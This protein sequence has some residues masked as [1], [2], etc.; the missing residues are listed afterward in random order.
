MSRQSG[1]FLLQ[2]LLALSLVFAFVPFV[3]SRLAARDTDAQMYSTTR[4]VETASI[5][6]R[7]FIRENANYLPYD[8]TVI[9]GDAFADTL[10][11]YGL[12]LGF[13]PHTALGQDIALVIEKSPYEVTAR[14][15]LTDGG[16]SWLRRAEL[17]RRI[18]FYAG[19]TDGMIVVG[20]PL[21]EAFT[22][23]VRRDG[24]T[25]TGFLTDLDMGANT[26]DNAGTVFAYRGMFNALESRG[27]TV[28]G[29][30]NGRKVRSQI[31]TMTASRAV[32]QSTSGESALSLTR[33]ELS[34]GSINART[35]ARFGD[36]GSFT[37]NAAGVYDFSMTA[38]RTG[39]TG[40][41]EW[42][43]RGSVVA[44]RINFNVERL[45]ISASI[46]AT[47]GQDVFVMPDELEYSSKSG[48]EADILAASNITLRDQTSDALVDGQ[49]G[50]VV[51]DIRPAGVS[52]LPD[53]LVDG[54]DNGAF[55]ILKSAADASSD[56]VD[57]KSVI[58]SLDG[59]YNQKSMAQY[60]ICQYVYW[61]RLEKRID[62]KQ[63][64]MDGRSD[65][66]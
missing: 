20:V 39:F 14:L 18:G 11:A 49:S 34:L 26:L 5:A 27:L 4:Q 15:E 52:V 28:T 22:D 31:D 48:I 57:C 42:N 64:L 58:S 47:R 59:N 55:A 32:F 36:A 41:G 66:M 21:E 17:V 54:V 19:I 30:E 62:I 1:N 46:N 45:D 3:A 8:T 25:D 33:G 16:L 60:I 2:A 50:A 44:D 38:G 51:I 12:P 23:V 7:I 24:G 35:V 65:C 6:A 9:S 61:Q 43:V 37:A 63:C 56:T 53:A 40:P 29:V 10:E 13:V